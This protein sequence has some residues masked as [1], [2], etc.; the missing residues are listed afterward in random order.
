MASHSLVFTMLLM[1]WTHPTITVMHSVT[2]HRVTMLK[3]RIQEVLHKG[4]FA[5]TTEW[6]WSRGEFLLLLACC[7]GGI[8]VSFVARWNFPWTAETKMTILPS[9]EDGSHMGSGT[10]WRR[11]FSTGLLGPSCFSAVV[12]LRRG[13]LA[14]GCFGGSQCRQ[15]CV[16]KAGHRNWSK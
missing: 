12:F 7:T 10:F 5:Q 11:L 1:L 6:A 14:M 13:V 8:S 9:L 15:V 4:S 3:A 16:I 2:A